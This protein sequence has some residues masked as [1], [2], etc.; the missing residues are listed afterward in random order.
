MVDLRKLDDVTARLGELVLDP[1]R[2][3]TFMDEVCAAVGA[4]GAAMLQSDVRTEDIPRTESVDD[5]FT[6]VYFPNNLHLTDIRAARG[7]RGCS[8]APMSSPTPICSG[9]SAR[10]CAIRST[11][12]SASSA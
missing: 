9:P 5:Y 7:C 6:R 12:V 11:P 8:V 3:P 2:W 4:T 10:C 1:A